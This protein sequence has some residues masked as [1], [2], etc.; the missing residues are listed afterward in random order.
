MSGRESISKRYC[1]LSGP[2]GLLGDDTPCLPTY[3]LS[4]HPSSPVP[5]LLSLS[6]TTYAFAPVQ[7][8]TVDDTMLRAHIA[9]TCL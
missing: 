2:S 8:S 4:H 6:F 3:C 9:V 1:G 5:S 7:G